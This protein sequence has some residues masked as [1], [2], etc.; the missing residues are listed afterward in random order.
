MSR[1]ELLFVCL[2]NDYIFFGCSLKTREYALASVDVTELSGAKAAM[3][4]IVASGEAL[5]GWFCAQPLLGPKGRKTH[6]IGK[7]AVEEAEGC[8][9]AI[10][11]CH[12][13]RR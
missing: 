9:W 10:Y 7:R 6:S 11:P 8:V 2:F 13:I 1:T 5:D 4:T 3:E 12:V